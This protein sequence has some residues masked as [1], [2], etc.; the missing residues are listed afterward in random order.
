MN[1]AGGVKGFKKGCVMY[2]IPYIGVFGAEICREERRGRIRY[3]HEYLR[4]FFIC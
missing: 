2:Y 4:S 3:G 1:S